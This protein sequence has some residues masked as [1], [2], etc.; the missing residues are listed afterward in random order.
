M[1]K[2][3]KKMFGKF[4]EK[5]RYWN[6]G[7]GV[8]EHNTAYPIFL[9]KKKV[10]VWGFSNDF[11]DNVVWLDIDGD[12]AEHESLSAF[13]DSLDDEEKSEIDLKAQGGAWAAEN[14]GAVQDYW[15]IDVL[16][17]VGYILQ[18]TGYREEWQYVSS[19]LTK[20]A[21]EA[22]ITRKK[23]DY[24][25]GMRVFVDAQVYCWEYQEIIKGLL[26]GKI[27]YQD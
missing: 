24:P 17:A 13:F 5:L 10:K 20:E 15:Q 22:F 11:A 26:D 6:E 25:L 2:L 19:H 27:A 7:E 16:Q 1:N 14:F 21:A 12:Y 23:H 8:Q 18:E 4:V 9:V 3:T